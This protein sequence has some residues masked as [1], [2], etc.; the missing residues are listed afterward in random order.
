M[1]TLIVYKDICGKLLIVSCDVE[2]NSGPSKTCR[3]VKNLCLIEQCCVHVDIV[4]ENKQN[5]CTKVQNPRYK[6]VT[7][8]AYTSA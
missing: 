2:I 1:M 6:N 4:L 5:E 3:S 7:L 8:N